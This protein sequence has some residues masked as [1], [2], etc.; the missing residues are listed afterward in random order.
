MEHLI[1]LKNIYKIYQMGD[2]AVHALDD[3]PI[4]V[5]VIKV[6]KIG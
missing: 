1:E 3:T 6:E 2:T 5:T 4:A